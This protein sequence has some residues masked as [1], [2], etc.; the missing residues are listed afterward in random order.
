MEK[1]ETP[2]A[3]R[4]FGDVMRGENET[5][6]SGFVCIARFYFIFFRKYPHIY[7]AFSLVHSHIVDFV[8]FASF[9]RS[10]L[11]FMRNIYGLWFTHTH[12]YN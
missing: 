9:F 2:S 12:R 10:H 5:G 8:N 1:K 6:R 7:P 3:N 4:R 11:E